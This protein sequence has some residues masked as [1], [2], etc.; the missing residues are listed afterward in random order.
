MSKLETFQSPYGIA[1]FP[2]LSKADTKHDASGV[3]HTDL[4]LPP[5]LAEDFIAKLERIRDEFAASLPQAQQQ[6][7]TPRPVSSLEYT[8]PEYP[9]GATDAE[10]TAIKQAHVPELTGN[11]L[12]RFKLKASVTP[13]NGEPFTQAPVIVMADSGAACDKPVYGGSVI[14]VRGQVVPYTNASAANYGVTLRLKA[15][16]VAELNSGSGESAGTHWTDFSDD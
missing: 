10:K 7:L 9:E 16:Q 1:V 15:V 3:Y 14:R 5:E 4:A 11:V 13:K 8:R 2:W 6:Q 12:F